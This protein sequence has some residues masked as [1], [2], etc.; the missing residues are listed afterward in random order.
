MK[1]VY[2][3]QGIFICLEQAMDC[4]EWFPPTILDNCW[5]VYSELF[6]SWA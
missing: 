1:V 6:N 4:A 2:H 3:N 5:R